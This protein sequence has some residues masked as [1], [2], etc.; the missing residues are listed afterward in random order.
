MLKKI[1]TWALTLALVLTFVPV[2]TPRAQ[3]TEQ[4]KLTGGIRPVRSF[5]LPANEAAKL[6]TL[7][8]AYHSSSRAR[9]AAPESTVPGGTR[10][11][12][13]QLGKIAQYG[14]ALQSMYA[15]LV[16]HMEAAYKPETVYEEMFIEDLTFLTAGSIDISAL[17][18]PFVTENDEAQ[19]WGLLWMAVSVFIQDNPQYYM[20]SSTNLILNDNGTGVSE[21]IPVLY[22]EYES[23]ESRAAANALIEERYNE[24][25]AVAARVSTDAD[26]ARI[27]HDKMLAERDYSIIDG[28]PDLNAYAH[29]ILGV[30]DL[31]TLGPVCESYA[32]AYAYILTRLG[33]PALNVVGDAYS[34]S[35]VEA[36]AW[37]MVQIGDA[38]YYV[39][40]TWN[41]FETTGLP[42]NTYNDDG[43]WT[44]VLYYEHFL[45]GSGNTDFT[46]AHVPGLATPK[47]HDPN[48]LYQVTLPEASVTDYQDSGSGK[49]LTHNPRYNYEYEYEYG[50]ADYYVS[51]TN[52]LGTENMYSPYTQD[53]LFITSDGEGY[54]WN[55]EITRSF[56]SYTISPNATEIPVQGALYEW[57]VDASQEYIDYMYI[58]PRPLTQ[59]TDYEII[60]EKPYKEGLNRAYIYG[61]G[62][63]KGIDFA[64]VTLTFDASL[65]PPVNNGDDEPVEGG[66]EPNANESNI[67][68]FTKVLTYE[69]NFDDIATFWGAAS[70]IEGFE[71]GVITGAGAGKY[72]PFGP[73]T[74]Q[75]ALTIAA[76]IHNIYATGEVYVVNPDSWAAD[77]IAYA[78]ENGLIAADDPLLAD[79]VKPVNRAEVIHLWRNILLEKDLPVIAENI[80]FADVTEETLYY[81][82]IMYLA[83]AGIVTGGTDGFAPG[84][85]FTRGMAAALFLKFLTIRTA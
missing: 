74:V 60:V 33:I 69:S 45:V 47:P 75:T 40:S 73:L 38:W 23:S 3:A 61:L 7:A 30:L 56:G 46:Y 29:N 19:A 55:D 22:D 80:T 81:E 53:G 4:Q 32:N 42:D 27:V 64:T 65:D 77:A 35:G 79:P 2:M 82:D 43:N 5:V 48:V 85:D 6:P 9:L 24:Y 44:N 83:R 78:V 39:D 13:E 8:T 68:N 41:D 66:D 16:T 59:G 28:T 10:Y 51:L 67:A 58:N 17:S 72:N 26:K 14:T 52:K 54:Y 21:L 63:Y 84:A 76:K 31:S 70:V 11:G 37:N 49:W 18:I 12:Y 25:A 57:T 15:A 34:D 20:I 62:D 71:Y 36:H 50:A 1:L